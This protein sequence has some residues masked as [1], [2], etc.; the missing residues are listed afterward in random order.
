MV[1][2]QAIYFRHLFLMPLHRQQA[3][4]D[5][6]SA[7]LEDTQL[8]VRIGAGTTLS[9]MIRCSGVALRSSVIEKVC[10]RPPHSCSIIQQRIFARMAVLLMLLPVD[11]EIHYST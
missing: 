2:I 1:N 8:E 3:L 5:C 6:I 9:G 11:Q 4:F 10:L 7:M